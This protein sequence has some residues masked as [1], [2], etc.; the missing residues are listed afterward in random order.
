MVEEGVDG[1]WLVDGW[2]TPLVEGWGAP[3]VEGVGE[4]ADG[5]GGVMAA[6]RF[7]SAFLLFAALPFDF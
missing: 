6:M 4:S 2:G 1:E 5:G 3:L 7:S